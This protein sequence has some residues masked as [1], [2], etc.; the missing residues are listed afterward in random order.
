MRKGA[1]IKIPTILNCHYQHCNECNAEEH[2]L[3]TTTTPWC[4]TP[5][6]ESQPNPQPPRP[7]SRP[8]LPR[9]SPPNSRPP[10]SPMQ[11]RKSSTEKSYGRKIKQTVMLGCMQ[12]SDA[13]N[14]YYQHAIWTLSQTYQ[15]IRINQMLRVNNNLKEEFLGKRLS[16]GDANNELLHKIAW[17]SV[18][19]DGSRWSETNDGMDDDDS[20]WR[21][22]WWAAGLKE[23]QD[24]GWVYGKG[25]SDIMLFE[26]RDKVLRVLTNPNT[27]YQDI[28]I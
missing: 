2:D 20:E 24:L 26:T 22:W 15:V 5:G 27:H 4:M 18:R 6:R 19:W 1:A 14:V 25:G 9:R 28:Y 8:K 10:T 12:R 21:R 13:K 11:M 3:T 16:T 23:H 17:W 7:K